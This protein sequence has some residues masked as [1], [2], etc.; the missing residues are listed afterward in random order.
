MIRGAD[1]V[2]A[3]ILAFCDSDTR[4]G[5]N[6]LREL[7]ELL[8]EDDTH[9]IAF[10]PTVAVAHDVKLGDVG[11][12][13]LQN[14]WYGAAVDRVAGDSGKVPFAMGQFMLIRRTALDAIGTMRAAEGEL[15]DDMFLG[16]RMNQFG[17]TNVTAR[18]RVPIIVGGMRLGE[19]LRVFRKWIFFSRS[20]LPA[21]FKT[22][23]WL[24]AVPGFAGWATL[25]AG[26]VLASPAAMVAGAS[27]LA[28]FVFSQV[29]LSHVLGGTQVAWRH[30]WLAAIMP[31]LAAG[32]AV[33][34]KLNHDV[35]WRGRRYHLDGSG[36]LRVVA[37]RAPIGALPQR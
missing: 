15:V 22:A 13:L 35:D 36:R 30:Y 24:R 37:P 16:R 27:A 7:V 10:A 32:V 18:T 25:I 29:R 31:F 26:I 8:E 21:A 33:S 34:T 23:G 3:D 19:F 5:P 6:V 28:A 9:G 1:L 11:Y 2:E 17:F 4:P 14:A 20:G 12:T